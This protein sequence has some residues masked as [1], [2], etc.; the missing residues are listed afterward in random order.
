MLCSCEISHFPVRRGAIFLVRDV[1]A[2][3]QVVTAAQ[4]DA[5]MAEGATLGQRGTV[6]FATQAG[7]GAEPT[8]G[9][10]TTVG[11]DRPDVAGPTVG[12]TGKG[13]RIETKFR[14]VP[15]VAAR[16]KRPRPHNLSTT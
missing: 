9:E 7:D 14:E 3:Q 16:R 2:G 4:G 5:M 1:K 6:E 13:D 12:N 8:G 10:D 15:T 11:I